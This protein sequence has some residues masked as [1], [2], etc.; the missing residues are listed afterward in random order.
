MGALEDAV[1][2]WRDQAFPPG[3]ATDAL[4]ELHADLALADTWVAESVI[5]FVEHGLH[6]PARV[7]VVTGL[8]DLGARAGELEQ[9][10][11]TGATLTTAPDGTPTHSQCGNVSWRQ[12]PRDDR[13]SL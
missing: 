13:S 1:A 3:S 9:R 5:P 2:T 11:S 4:D 6:K 10:K 7:D 12:R 8:R